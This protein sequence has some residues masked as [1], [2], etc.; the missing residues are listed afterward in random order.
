MLEQLLSTQEA[1][2]SLA[3][4]KNKTKQKERMKKNKTNISRETEE[5][6]SIPMTLHNAFEDAR[7]GCLAARTVSGKVPPTGEFRES[8]QQSW[9]PGLT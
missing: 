8:M 1:L 9:F 3:N 5:D 6:P 4:T 7:N 2:G